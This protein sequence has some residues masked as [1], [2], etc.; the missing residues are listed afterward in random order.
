MKG[1]LVYI[2]GVGLP[3]IVV[4]TMV[5]PVAFHIGM[6]IRRAG[7]ALLLP[8][9]PTEDVEAVVEDFIPSKSA[10]Q[11]PAYVPGTCAELKAMGLRNFVVGEPNYTPE[12]DPDNNG[13]ACED[14]L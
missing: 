2:I 4:G 14:R 8:N 10:Y 9:Q 13:L 6:D 11:P 3:G 12:R 1:C 5:I 7:V